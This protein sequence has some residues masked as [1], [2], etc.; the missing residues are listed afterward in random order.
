M[1][2]VILSMLVTSGWLLNWPQMIE[3]VEP[4]KE[5]P[6]LPMSVLP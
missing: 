4:V 3:A 6:Q 5:K 2:S 1:P